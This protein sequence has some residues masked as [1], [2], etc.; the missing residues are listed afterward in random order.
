M[1][2]GSKLTKGM[3][4]DEH[5]PKAPLAICY[6]VFASSSFLQQSNRAAADLVIEPDRVSFVCCVFI[7][8][9]FGISGEN[10]I[11]L[12]DEVKMAERS[13]TYLSW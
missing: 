2:P 9:C 13:V 12:V 7:L 3:S 1:V 8:S 10:Q 6:F 11:E 4:T 5:R